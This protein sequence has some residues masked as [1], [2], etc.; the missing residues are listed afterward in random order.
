MNTI[1]SKVLMMLKYISILLSFFLL[2]CGQNKIKSEFL[3]SNHSKKFPFLTKTNVIVYPNF[4]EEDKPN[5]IRY[6]KYGLFYIGKDCD[7]ISLI[8]QYNFSR[9]NFIPPNSIQKSSK[10]IES[11][12]KTQL[13]KYYIEW[14]KNIPHK[15]FTDTLLEIQANTKIK[16]KNSFPVILRN[17]NRDTIAIGYGSHIK[18]ILEAKD[19]LGT[20][21][22]IQKDFNYI[23]GK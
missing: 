23:C 1:N 9:I 19:S 22:P 4:I 5:G 20:W 10:E 18:L 13:D 15:Y 11:N 7:S 17:L 14:D 16:I 8:N 3:I 12:N 2:N 6:S 21:K